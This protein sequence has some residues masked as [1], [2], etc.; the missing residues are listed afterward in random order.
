MLINHEPANLIL[1]RVTDSEKNAFILQIIY[2]RDH[3]KYLILQICQFHGS[4]VWLPGTN[5]VEKELHKKLQ[6]LN[7]GE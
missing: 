6:I 4:T 3:A 7:K 5:Y 2:E 1:Y